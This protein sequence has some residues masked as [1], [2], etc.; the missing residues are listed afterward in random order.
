VTQSG[1]GGPIM[2]EAYYTF[3][4]TVYELKPY[5]ILSD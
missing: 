3:M 2:K 5:I 1:C 4:K